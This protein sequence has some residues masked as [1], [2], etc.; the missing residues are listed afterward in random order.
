MKLKTVMGIENEFKLLDK[1]GNILLGVDYYKE[2]LNK[3]EV[4]YFKVG[5]T[6]SRLATGGAFYIDGKEPEVT[7]APYILEKGAVIA[8][9]T[10][11]ILNRN[12][13][14]D[15]LNRYNKNDLRLDGYSTHYNFTLPEIKSK[16]EE[17]NVCY[18]LTKTVNPALQL[19][20]ENRYSEGIMFRH[21]ENGRIEICADYI[22]D[23]EDMVAAVGF[24]V[25]M[26][27]SIDKLLREGADKQEI[28]KILKYRIPKNPDRTATRT[29]FILKTPEVIRKGRTAKVK[30]LDYNGREH[31][32]SAQKLLEEYYKI[33]ENSI[34]SELSDEEKKILTDYVEGKRK[35][36]IDH[37]GYPDRYHHVK[38]TPI[39]FEKV[40]T[41]LMTA[42]GN[43][44]SERKIGEY[45]LSPENLSWK[46]VEFGINSTPCGKTLKVGIDDLVTFDK[47]VEDN[48]EL[49]KRMLSGDLT[50]KDRVILKE[51]DISDPDLQFRIEHKPKDE[52]R[53]ISHDIPVYPDR[54]YEYRNSIISLLDIA[55]IS[56]RIVENYNINKI[57]K[58]DNI[59]LENIL[60][61]YHIKKDIYKYVDIKENK[62]IPYGTKFI[63]LKI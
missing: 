40:K 47:L 54:P 61:E 10:N 50:A 28:E 16:A 53:D 24:Q 21:R 15:A 48:I 39:D 57:I 8:L 20:L 32:I 30:V 35:L 22:P 12:V 41:P 14:V 6:S 31:D 17:K 25:A 18:I 5:L 23:L 3:L 36:P 26:L 38:V 63:S 42:L 29:G 59:N 1:N 2:I 51:L 34:N 19:F 55:H 45:V 7:T 9:V 27:T 4:P 60:I 49:V 58:K 13:V 37:R 44:V 46:E 56:N 43:A 52:I 62:I 33:F 11:L